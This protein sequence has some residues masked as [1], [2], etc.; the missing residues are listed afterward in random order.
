MLF[1]ELKVQQKS[2]GGVRGR[3]K[4]GSIYEVESYEMDDIKFFLSYKNSTHV[5]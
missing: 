2:R 3:E 4:T 5:V 1:V